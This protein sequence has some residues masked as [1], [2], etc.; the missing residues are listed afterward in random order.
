MADTRVIIIGAGPAG[1]AAAAELARAGQDCVLIDQRATPGGAIH[2]QPAHPSRTIPMSRVARLRFESLMKGIATP[3]VQFRGLS[4]FL[5]VDGDGFALIEDRTNG[6]VEKLAAKA[7][8]LAT[9]AVE[10]IRPVQ[11]WELPGVSTAGGMQVMLK[12]TGIAP[13][14]RILL[15][16]N[17][18]LLVALA[19]QLIRAG[20]PPLALVEAANPMAKPL[21]ALGL[22]RHPALLGEAAGFTFD[23]LR[24]G[25]PWMRG[26]S[27]V[28]IEQA[29]SALAAVIRQAGG[30]ETRIEVDRIALHDGIRENRIGLPQTNLQGAPIIVHAGDCRQ[31]LGAPAA[32]C[33]GARAGRQVAALLGANTCDVAKLERRLARQVAAQKRLARIFSPVAALPP[34][35]DL[36]DETVICRCEGSTVGSLKALLSVK[37]GLSGR[38][39]KHNGRFAMGNCQGRFCAANTAALM[40]QLRPDM[41]EASEADLT[42][43][44]WPIRPVSIAALL[45]A[46]PAEQTN[47]HE[48]R[49]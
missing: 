35:K 46:A 39:V 45:S 19:A 12:E 13:Q 26:A 6:R 37:D 36:P 27:L 2:R 31:T 23:V 4:H 21:A 42:G 24:S 22:L 44:R 9:G 29:G 28:R 38:E 11:G 30:Q 32:V 1:L 20:N 18:P 33:D 14:G 40:A 48:V 41:P 16:G 25:L 7:I 8:I 3:R 17:G 5:G 47:D 15:A 43:R 10:K 49:L 34:L